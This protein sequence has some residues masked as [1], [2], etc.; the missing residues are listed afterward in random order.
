MTQCPKDSQVGMSQKLHQNRGTTFE[1][2]LFGSLV[3]S[4][5]LEAMHLSRTA[6][7]K[8]PNTMPWITPTLDGAISTLA[9]HACISPGRIADIG[10]S[11]TT[12]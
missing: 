10:R 3:P 4:H 8:M 6:S 5:G 1:G 7:L 11:P 12:G 2:G 9:I